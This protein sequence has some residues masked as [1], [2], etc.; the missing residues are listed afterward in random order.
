MNSP[1]FRF[2]YDQ[3]PDDDKRAFYAALE[4]A[5]RSRTERVVFPALPDTN[6]KAYMRILEYIYDD[7]PEFFY[8]F[9]LR[10]RIRVNDGSVVILPFYRY[11][12]SET[13]L[14]E[15]RLDRTVQDVLN[16]CFPE[17][18]ESVSILRREKRIF[19]WIVENVTYDHDSEYIAG[20][21]PIEETTSSAAWN[22]YGA[23]VLRNAVCEGIACSF[24]LLCDRVN[25]PSIVAIGRAGGERHAWNII[26]INNRF[27]HVDC[28]WDLRSSISTEVPY[29]RYRYFNLPDRIIE[30]NHRPEAQFL[31]VCGSLRYN[32]FRMKGLCAES[33]AE[34]R[35]IAMKQA[36]QGERRF[37]VMTLG[38]RAEDYAADTAEAI[39]DRLHCRV[40]SY[41]DSSGFFAGFVIE[42]G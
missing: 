27:Y 38:F 18:W 21:R 35:Q 31:P 32:P 14:Y 17:G 12:V 4:E 15:T 36:E 22:A 33:P 1:T 6:A 16:S 25:V 5:V 37:A 8:F 9:P 26:G 20:T 13:R 10:S 28:T 24:K 34:L 3:L 23:L 19:D 40:Y 30:T 42:K 41:A 39:R 7:H 11:S 2:F 29:A